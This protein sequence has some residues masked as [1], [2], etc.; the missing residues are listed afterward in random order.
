[1]NANA[2]YPYTFVNGGVDNW[3]GEEKLPDDCNMGTPGAP[4]RH[5]T[6]GDMDTTL[7]LVV[8]GSCTDEPVGKVNA[9]F[10]VDM[11]RENVSAEGVQLVIKG[12]WI[13]TAMTDKGN[14]IWEATLILNQ[15]STYPYT[16]V[17]GAEDDWSGEESVPEECNF[18]TFSA[19]ER[20]LELA[21]SD[22]ILAT[23]SFGACSMVTDVNVTFRVD[24]KGQTVSGDGVQVHLKEPWLWTAMT[25]AGD[26]IWV[27]TIVLPGNTTYPYSFI[28]GAVDYWAGE[29]VIVGDCKDGENNQRLAQIGGVDIT[30]PAYAFGTCTDRTVNVNTV[31]N[32][33]FKVYPNPASDILYIDL[34][35]QVLNRVSI[36]D[37]TGRVMSNYRVENMGRISLDVSGLKGGLYML[38]LEGE[39]F[40]S[41][42]RVSINR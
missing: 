41:V 16:F 28:N 36:I 33:T 12:P 5:V 27:A 20:R 22:T 13:W 38:L 8:F 21:E 37:V 24:M 40:K 1:V 2:T 25:D 26:D 30:L 34:N 32:E 9:T 7:S 42:A 19:P 35:E 15:N 3:G 17:N 11:S 31:E 18:G 29:E 23:V 14:G 10:S 4:E 39:G 6:V